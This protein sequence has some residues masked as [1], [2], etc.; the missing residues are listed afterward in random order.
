MN[1]V[2][3]VPLE[4]KYLSYISK[5]KCY[6]IRN[7]EKTIRYYNAHGHRMLVLLK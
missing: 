1:I 2:G 6:C 4:G 7:I 3:Q 5:E